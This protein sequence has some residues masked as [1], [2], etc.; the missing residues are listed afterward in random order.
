VAN[1]IAQRCYLSITKF[2]TF[3]PS[4]NNYAN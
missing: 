3:Q 1:S 4:P 2:K